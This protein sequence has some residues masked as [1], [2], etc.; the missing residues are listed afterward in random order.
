MPFVLEV[1]NVTHIINNIGLIKKR[2]FNAFHFT[3]HS[4]PRSRRHEVR[5]LLGK[6]FKSHL[7]ELDAEKGSN[8]GGTGCILR[9]Q[10]QH[11]MQPHA[12]HPD[13]Q[14]A[15]NQGRVGMYAHEVCKDTH[16]IIYTVYGWTNGLGDAEAAA[17][18]DDLLSLICA[19]MDLQEEG[20]KLVVGDLNGPLEAFIGFH[21]SIKSGKLVDIGAIASAFGGVDGDTTCKANSKSKAT[22][23]DYIIANK[24]AEDLIDIMTVDHDP[25]FPVHDVLRVTFKATAPQHTYQAVAIPATLKQLFLRVLF[26]DYGHL[27]KAVHQNKEQEQQEQLSRKFNCEVDIKDESGNQ[28]TP[29]VFPKKK[30]RCCEEDEKLIKQSSD[31]H[32]STT[33][34]SIE[35]EI[36]ENY[37]TTQKAT[38]LSRLHLLIHRE[39]DKYKHR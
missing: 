26:K 28:L 33:N 14:R 1:G 21:M 25:Q 31:D 13:L 3:E 19:D 7:S 39:L 10:T 11:I 38:S 23:R 29:P 8:V 32:D 2:N 16:V 15:I 34:Q 24:A 17:R 37:T 36:A 9:T 27:N 18:T 12:K 6:G 5:T 22:R 20:P 4:I 35:Q 30:S